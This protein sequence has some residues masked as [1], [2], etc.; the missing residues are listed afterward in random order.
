MRRQR[1]QMVKRWPMRGACVTSCWSTKRGRTTSSLSYLLLCRP[2]GSLAARSSLNFWRRF[3]L[4]WKSCTPRARGI[5]T[6]ICVLSDS[7]LSSLCIH[8]VLTVVC[9][10]Y[11]S[12]YNGLVG[13]ASPLVTD[14]DSECASPV[15]AAQTS[16]AAGKVFSHPAPS[17]C[18]FERW[19]KTM[20]LL[21]NNLSLLTF[22]HPIMW[23][24]AWHQLL[25]AVG[26]RHSRI[27]CPRMHARLCHGTWEPPLTPHPVPWSWTAKVSTPVP[28]GPYETPKQ[29]EVLSLQ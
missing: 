26:R 10:H 1:W 4:L 2:A 9:V 3:L 14:R 16:F 20:R 13:F 23:Y 27:Q 29:E 8:P 6:H 19:L 25:D 24:M 28:R 7:L 18:V 11:C 12:V 21:S 15:S 17:L 5:L 22:S